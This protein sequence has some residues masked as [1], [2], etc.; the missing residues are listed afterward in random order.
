MVHLVRHFG[1][2]E[3]SGEPCGICDICAPD[4]CIARRFREPSKAEQAHVARIL[5]ALAE[6]DGQATGRL[7]RETFPNG[8]LDRRSFEHLL[9][10]LVAAGLVVIEETSFEKD[11]KT[12]PFER[13]S[14]TFKGRRQGAS[15]P[16]L[17]LPMATTAKKTARDA[18][19]R[20]S[21]AKRKSTAKT[22]STAKAK[23][24]AKASAAAKRK[25]AFINKN[26]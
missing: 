2:Q 8:D 1:D 13:A 24:S 18:P 19:I 12:I 26:R 16:R 20:R 17:A 25:W 3:D 15:A 14:L 10:G 4:R 22:G 6:G 7:H 9:G 5:A 23:P 21:G 11:G